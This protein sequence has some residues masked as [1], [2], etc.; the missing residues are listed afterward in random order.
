MQYQMDLRKLLPPLPQGPHVHFAAKG[1]QGWLG[2]LLL[3][4]KMQL[5]GH[6]QELNNKMIMFINY[7]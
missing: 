6:K 7:G 2:M 4:D 3:R 1:P 5:P